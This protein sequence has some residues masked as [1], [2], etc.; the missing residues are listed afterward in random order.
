MRREHLSKNSFE[1]VEK[2]ASAR[3]VVAPFEFAEVFEKP[4]LLVAE[5]DGGFNDDLDEKVTLAASMDIRSSFRADSENLAILRPLRDA[6]ADLA[7]SWCGHFFLRAKGRF[8]KS[9]GEL[10]DHIVSIALKDIVGFYGDIDIEV[11]WRASSFAC[12]AI[13]AHA[14]AHPI[15]NPSWD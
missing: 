9:D 13:A 4:L 2:G 7:P 15:V 5:A 1:F 10:D 11:A 12:I 8:R 3:R 6:D 14:E